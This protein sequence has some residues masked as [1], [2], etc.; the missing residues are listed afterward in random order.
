MKRENENKLLL[1][2]NWRNH[3]FEHIAEIADLQKGK[4]LDLLHVTGADPRNTDHFPLEELAEIADE[5]PEI[6]KCYRCDVCGLVE[7]LKKDLD[8]ELLLGEYQLR[9]VIQILVLAYFIKKNGYEETIFYDAYSDYRLNEV[10]ASMILKDPRCYCLKKETEGT[11][12]ADAVA[13]R[14]FYSRAMSFS[15]HKPKFDYTMEEKDVRKLCRKIL[16]SHVLE[17]LEL[18]EVDYTSINNS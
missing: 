12:P 2:F 7:N 10:P 9:H 5:M 15:D 6:D 3:S 1:P 18:E 8:P 16:R 11:S 14:F 13:K 17:T 4:T